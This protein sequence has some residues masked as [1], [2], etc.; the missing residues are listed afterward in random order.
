MEPIIIQPRIEGT[1]LAY[2]ANGFI[3]LNNVYINFPFHWRSPDN[4]YFDKEKEEEEE[5]DTYPI[6]PR[7][8]GEKFDLFE[9]DRYLL[10]SDCN[11]KEWMFQDELYCL[12]DYCIRNGEPI[13]ARYVNSYNEEEIW[14]VDDED[15]F[16]LDTAAG[17]NIFMRDYE[18]NHELI[19]RE[20]L[21]KVGE[22]HPWIYSYNFKALSE[23]KQDLHENL[24]AELCHPRRIEKWLLDGNDLDDY[25][26]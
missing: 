25:L 3:D 20:K 2:D 23:S 7:Y 24:I 13:I 26:P 8:K 11:P 18:R 9:D 19:K 21:L 15:D 22:Y 5:E 17:I 10:R 12:F 16:W 4:E 14:V 6:S 1:N